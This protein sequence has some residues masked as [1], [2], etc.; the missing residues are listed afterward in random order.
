MGR[1]RQVGVKEGKEREREN[2]SSIRHGVVFVQRKEGVTV[3]GLNKGI[4]GL[5]E[6]YQTTDGGRSDGVWVWFCWKGEFGG[7][8][9]RVV[10]AGS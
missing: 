6:G 8:G 10:G 5:L 7:K 1:Y 3:A 2:G 4:L 9:S